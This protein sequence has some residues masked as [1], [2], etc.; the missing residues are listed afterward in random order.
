ME[1]GHKW[2]HR[3]SGH[4]VAGVEATKCA[5]PNT[6]GSWDGYCINDEQVW[7]HLGKATDDSGHPMNFCKYHNRTFWQIRQR[8]KFN[9]I[10]TMRVNV[11]R[12]VVRGWK[13][14]FLSCFVM[15][16][17]FLLYELLYFLMALL[18]LNSFYTENPRWI[19]LYIEKG[20][21]C[22]SVWLVLILW[23][24]ITVVTGYCYYSTFCTACLL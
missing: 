14:L 4:F 7:D 12:K 17:T 3:L 23:K 22:L 24:K 9:V 19:P 2:F 1:V 13:G 18:T 11:D 10:P 8:S 5:F 16:M 20:P 21:E 6:S 15:S